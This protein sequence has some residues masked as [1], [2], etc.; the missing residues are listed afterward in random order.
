MMLAPTT[1]TPSTGRPAGEVRQALLQ[2][3][4]QLQTPDRAPTVRE[5][6]AAA[7]VSL[8]AATQ[9]VKNLK[10]AGLLDIAR[11]RQVAY[12]NRPVAEYTSGAPW[13]GGKGHTSGSCVL[14]NI[15]QTWG[16]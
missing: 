11:N 6:A 1:S 13:T 15:L 5:L 7:K 2:A 8:K 3:C 12:R 4:M 14:A 9:T 10:R 16:R